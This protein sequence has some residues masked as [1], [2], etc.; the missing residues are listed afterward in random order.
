[1]G[2]GIKSTIFEFHGDFWHGNP[3][4]YESQET[5]TI[6]GMTFGKLYEKTIMKEKKLKKLG[7]NLIVM[8]EYDWKK[9]INSIRILQRKFRNSKL[10]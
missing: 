8:W 4:V 7:Y 5:N 3:N 6:V 10:H 2:L 9:F 1:M